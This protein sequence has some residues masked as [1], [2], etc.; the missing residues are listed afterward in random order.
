MKTKDIKYVNIYLDESG[1]G[2]S[3]HF[4]VGGFY[5]FSSDLNKIYLQ[6]NKISKNIQSIEN[7]IRKNLLN[8]DIKKEIK[9]RNLNFKNKKL[10]FSSI[11]NYGQV[12]VSMLYNLLKL[13]EV[14]QKPILIEYIYN[15]MA[16][17]IVKNILFDLLIKGHIS[18]T[19]IISIRLNI[20]Q[21]RNYKN[22]SVENDSFKELAMYL[23][24]LMYEKSKFLNLRKIEVIQFDSK[25]KPTIRYA[26]YFIGLLSSVNRILNNNKRSYDIGSDKLLVLLNKKIDHINYKCEFS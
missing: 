19:D 23:N 3:S 16:F 20:D 2:S 6:D 12:N 26:D 14:R 11:R 1:S 22:S 7:I 15:I 10:L 25:N 24:T 8:K 18:T 5:L 17:N 9:F 4:L 21:R 13:K